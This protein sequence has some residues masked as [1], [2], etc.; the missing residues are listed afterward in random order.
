MVPVPYGFGLH[1]AT[2]WLD[3]RVGFVLVATILISACV[4]LHLIRW[5]L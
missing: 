3:W 2:L 4:R 1:L 5:N